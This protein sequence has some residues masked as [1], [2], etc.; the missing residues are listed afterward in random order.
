MD[1]QASLTTAFGLSDDE[2]L[3]YDSMCRREALPVVKVSENLT[4]TPSNIDLAKGETQFVSES[5]REDILRTCLKKTSLPKGTTILVDSPPSLGIL[6][7]TC[8]S[9]ATQLC[10]VV[11]P[12]G[13]ELRTLIHL[14]Q[15]V[16]LLRE[17][18]NPLLSIAG[19]VLTNCHLRRTITEQVYQEVGGHYF[20]LGRVRS[21]ARLLYATTAGQIHKLNRSNAMEDYASVVESLRMVVPWLQNGKAA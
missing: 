2:G 4:I 21:D 14:N 9:A 12:G 6:A 11:Q 13:F 1:P 16:E 7:V 8:L 17:H 5:A 19:V 20:V 15:T 3:L 10:V 18:V